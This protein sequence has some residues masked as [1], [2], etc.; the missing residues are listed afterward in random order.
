MPKMTVNDI[1]QKISFLPPEDQYVIAETLSKKV[2]DLRRKQLVLRAREAEENE[3]S[4]NMVIE[5]GQIE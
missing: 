4:C 3:K 5:S 2:R 1:L